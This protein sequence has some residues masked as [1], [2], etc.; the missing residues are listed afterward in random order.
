M[1]LI[2]SRYHSHSSQSSLHSRFP[3]L[4]YAVSPLLAAAAAAATG[5]LACPAALSHGYILGSSLIL[6]IRSRTEY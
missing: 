4:T 6:E 2:N 1:L 5:F 3:H